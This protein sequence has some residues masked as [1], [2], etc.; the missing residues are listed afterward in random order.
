[1]NRLM[2]LVLVFAV[3]LL[4][5]VYFFQA[6]LAIS[7]NWSPT[8]RQVVRVGFWVPTAVSFAALL[9]RQLADPYA[10]NANVRN[11]II[12][13]VFATYFSKLIGIIFLLIDDIQRLVRWV[14]ALFQ[15][16]AALPGTP[17]TRSQFL[18]QA[19]VVAS[20]VPFGAMVYG[21]VSGAHDY[22]V[23]KVT[24]K[25]PNLPHAFDG[26]R[27]AQLSDIH[28]GSFFNKTAVKG[29]VEMVL[30][31]KPD[32]IFFTGDLVN[33]ESAEVKEYIS[34]FDKLRAPLGVFSVTGN[35]D[36]GDYKS[37][38]SQA[39]KQQNF[40]DL[41]EAH[42]LLGFDLLMNEHRFITQG[43]SK[44]AIIGIENWGAGR[45]SKYGNLEQAYAGTNEAAVKL[46]L[47]HDPSHW[48]AQV[49]PTY[50]DID[51]AFAGHTHGFQFGVEVGNFK[52]SP[53]QYAYKQWAGLYTEGKQ[54]LYVN[55]GFGYLGYPGRVSMPPEITIMEL[56]RA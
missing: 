2:M 18:T 20:A 55:R 26:I 6:V 48:D 16:K 42:R 39:A 14:A 43:G 40:K 38:S 24:V 45:F 50:K 30:K 4:V 41:M 46:L 17:I 28:S 27:L 51:V 21:I 25:L 9:W 5:D 53:S 19:A 33:N 54:H 37:W 36:Y 49:R 29:G 13:G 56:K 8:W 1:M 47:S 35:H 15:K 31:E 32:L 34:V 3:L 11:W 7:K 12:T 22:R 10:I 44:L 52:W 23:R